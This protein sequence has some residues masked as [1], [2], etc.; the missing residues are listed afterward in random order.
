MHSRSTSCLW[1]LSCLLAAPVVRAQRFEL[2]SI[3][4]CPPKAVA[5]GGF[6]VNASPGRLTIECVSIETLVRDAYLRYADGKAWPIDRPTGLQTLPMPNGEI[7]QQIKGSAGWIASE[8]F[9]I[10]AKA[11]G[12]AI[13]E[14]MRGPMMRPVLADRFKLKFH[15]ETRDTPVYELIVAK[16]GPK[17]QSTTSRS[18][19]ALDPVKGA[20]GRANR[21]TLRPQY[22]EDFEGRTTEG[23]TSME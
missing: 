17:L 6:R 13:V 18:C 2:V 20:R 10:D 15:W 7:F 22:A 8:R 5:D 16:G 9:T 11:D 4:P 14:M 19:Q 1:V 12:P 21:G 23:W 3:R